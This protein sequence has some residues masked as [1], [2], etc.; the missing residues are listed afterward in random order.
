[1][2]KRLTGIVAVMAI[3]AAVMMLGYGCSDPTQDASGNLGPHPQGWLDQSSPGFHGA[4]V[5]ADSF[6]TVASCGN[7]HVTAIAQDTTWACWSCHSYYPHLHTNQ[8]IE[9]FKHGGAVRDI[10]YQVGTCGNCHGVNYSGGVAGVNCTLCHSNTPEACNTCHGQFTGNAGA[11]VNWAPPNSLSG[12][13]ESSLVTVGAHRQHLAPQLFSPTI[14]DPFSCTECHQLADSVEAVGH[15]GDSPFIAEIVFGT[16]AKTDNANPTWNRNN[17]ACSATYCHG[18]FEFG[19]SANPSPI[20]TN[21]DGSQIVCGT[22]H[23]MPPTQPDHPQ[24]SNCNL[25]HGSVVSPD[26]VT[27][28][29]PTLHVNGELNY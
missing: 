4:A 8:G 23:G 19:N 26:N 14:C 1:M 18:N 17:A 25:C 20:W 12:L 24:N 27:I 9:G 28:I 10:D 2:N 22:C 3:F 5:I 16:L 21:Q 6:N 15:L 29:G 11:A 7:C 13:S